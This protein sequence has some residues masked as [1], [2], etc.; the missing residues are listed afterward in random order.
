MPIRY[1]SAIS[2][3]L[4]SFVL[5]VLG[6]TTVLI[7]VKSVWVGFLVNVPLI[8]WLVHMGFNTYYIL[9]HGVLQITCGLFYK[10]N[11][12]IADITQIR[13]T[14]N[15]LSSPALSMERLEIQF[16]SKQSIMISPKAKNDFIKELVQQNPSIKV[17]M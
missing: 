3:W 1:N 13:A 15:P 10:E 17:K 11:F 7:I 5:L 4:A 6:S 16:K 9:D 2:G 12:L 14:N 8:V